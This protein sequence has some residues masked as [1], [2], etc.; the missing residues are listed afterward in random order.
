MNTK[1]KCSNRECSAFGIE[2]SVFVGQMLGY[3]AHNDPVTCSLC[4]NLMTT[5]ATINTSLKGR[6]SK[7]RGKS[8]SRKRYQ[9]RMPKTLAPVSHKSSFTSPRAFE[10][11]WSAVNSAQGSA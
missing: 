5:T 8:L 4:G 6:S 11:L 7:G 2:K 10:M 1:A 9:K 3:G